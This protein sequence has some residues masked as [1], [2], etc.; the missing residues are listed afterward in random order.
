MELI[1]YETIRS[2]HRAEKLDQLQKLPEGFFNSVRDWVIR[3]SSQNDNVSLLERENAKRILED[4][5]MMRHRKIVNSAL[6]ALKGVAPPQGLTEDE[7]KFFDE[8]TDMLRKSYQ[9]TQ[10][11]LIG[12][13]SIAE[14]KI[15]A[16]ASSV[17][18]LKTEKSITITEDVPAF[19]DEHLKTY[20]PFTKGMK[21]QAPEHIINMLVSKNS[22]VIP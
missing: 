19:V 14:E 11:M 8:L 18:E 17:T 1:S 13:D 7:R 12:F 5:I 9:N 3:K 4:I 2:V 15:R 16:A 21:V 10:G 22:A 6:N 20:G